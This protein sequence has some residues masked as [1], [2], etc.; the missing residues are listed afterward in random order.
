[1][2][3]S[4]FL[5]F[6]AAVCLVIFGKVDEVVKVTGIVRAGENVSQVRN[7]ISGKITQKNYRPGQEVKSG[8]V[9]FTIDSSVYDSRRENLV[10]EKMK[11]EE[12]LRGLE[13][14]LRSFETGKNLVSEE[15]QVA[16]SRYESFR[17]NREKLVVQRNISRAALQ[18]ERSLPEALKNQKTLRERELS[19]SYDEKNL[20]SYEAEFFRTLTEEKDNLRLSV[21]K[22]KQEI[23]QLDSQYQFLEVRSPVGGFVQEVSSINIGDYV[24]SGAQVLNIVPCNA[25][26]FKVEMQVSPKDMG[27]ISSGLKVKYR[28]S[29]FPFFEYR[30]AEGVIRAVDPDIRS[31][32]GGS[33]YYVVYADIDRINFEN[34]RGERF[35]IRAGLQTDARIVL[36]NQPLLVCILRKMDFMN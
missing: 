16:F 7:V 18:N 15:N 13:E 2:L 1:M 26:K 8:E 31:G 14:L 25:E 24:E 27:K 21:Y 23:S 19:L 5:L 28:L 35:P 30:G 9:L 6:I 33:L 36:K 4:V 29:A 3:Y 17:T 10:S 22:I 11:A 20:K 32:G 12:H 34:R